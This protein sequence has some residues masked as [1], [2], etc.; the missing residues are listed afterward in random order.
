[1]LFF[2]FFPESKTSAFIL[3]GA[4]ICLF[5]SCAFYIRIY[6]LGRRTLIDSLVI[7]MPPA[8][9]ASEGIGCFCWL[10]NLLIG[11]LFNYRYYSF[12]ANNIPNSEI[13][14]A[15]IIRNL[16]LPGKKASKISLTYKHLNQHQRQRVRNK[17]IKLLS[18]LP[19]C[20]FTLTFGGFNREICKENL[21][22]M[23]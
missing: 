7:Q 4:N 2:F 21:L 14:F 23:Y 5:Q 19:Y 20:L 15:G 22:Q 1:M 13:K 16:K 9:D 8:V 3:H 6:H 10:S 12:I 18:E 17:S 11:K